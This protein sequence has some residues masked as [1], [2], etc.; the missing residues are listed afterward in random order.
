M[1]YGLVVDKFL[2]EVEVV[3]K[4]LTGGLEQCRELQGAAIIECS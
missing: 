2:A 1:K 3:V 4:P